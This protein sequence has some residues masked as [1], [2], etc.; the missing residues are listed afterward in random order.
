MAEYY[1][2]VYMYHI[3]RRRQWHPTPVLLL[4]KSHGRRSLVGCRPWGREESDTA[5][6]L[7]FHFSLSCI[8]EGN[9]NPLQ[10]SC[11]ETG[12]PGGLPSMGSHRVG[13]DWSDLADLADHIFF[14]CSSIDGHLG[15]FHVL[16]I[17][18]VAAMDI[19]VHISFWMKVLS[20][21]IPRSGI[22]W[23]IGNSIFSFLQNLHT[24]FHSDYTSLHSHQECTCYFQPCWY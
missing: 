11:L 5:E 14:I 12:K 17:V 20:R 24:V 1:S 4:G 23:I 22:C 2:A 18:N 13:H 10:C 15:S 7:H 9:G 16:A 8:G 6:R 3:F 21:Y 19:G